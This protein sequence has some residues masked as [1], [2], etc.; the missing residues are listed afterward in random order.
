MEIIPE[1]KLRYLAGKHGF[2]ILYLEKDYFLTLLLYFIRNIKGI[3]F[4][5]GTALNKI[6]LNHKRLSQDLDFTSRVKIEKVKRQVDDALDKK[7]FKKLEI[8]HV[9]KN[10]IR[11]HIFFKSYFGN[12]SFI[13]LDINEKASVHLKPEKHRLKNFYGLDFYIH[14]LNLDEIIAE[15]V[16]TLVLRNQ[17]RDYFDIYFIIK[18]HKLNLSLIKKKLEEADAEFN[19]ERIFK[20]AQKIYSRWDKDLMSLTNKEVKFITVMKSLQKHFGYKGK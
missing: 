1:D 7:I 13:I 17:P 8:D 2:N 19:I 14:T 16:R 20:N 10:F 6:F 5:G 11:F 12:E 4:K 3:Y 15:K 18:K 9:T